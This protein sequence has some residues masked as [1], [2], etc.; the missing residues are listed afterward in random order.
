MEAMW[1]LHLVCLRLVLD[2]P[3]GSAN[4]PIMAYSKQRAEAFANLIA[5][6]E[7]AVTM[8]QVYS[9]GSTSLAGRLSLS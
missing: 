5:D 2:V 6:V 1:A 9:L 7:V 4:D 8:A 3:A